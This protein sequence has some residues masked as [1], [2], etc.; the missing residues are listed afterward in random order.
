MPT[1][2]KDLYCVQVNYTEVE[3]GKHSNIFS[4]YITFNKFKK[5]FIDERWENEHRSNPRST[6][7]GQ[8]FT[9]TTVKLSDTEYSI[10][11]FIFPD[12]IETAEQLHELHK[13]KQS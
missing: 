7:F 4:T 1:K 10:R 13:T 2:L 11:Q 6:L 3:D 9:T 12:S 8:Q 5:S